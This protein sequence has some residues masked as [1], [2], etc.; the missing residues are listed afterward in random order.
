[1]YAVQTYMSLS[2]PVK[3]EVQK[4]SGRRERA[5]QRRQLLIE[6]TVEIIGRDGIDAVNHRRVADLAGVPLGSTTYYFA[7]RE[8]MLVQALEHF[9]RG[10]IKAL[11][12]R[13]DGLPGEHG[14]H[15]LIEEFVSFLAP[16]ADDTRARTVAQYTL[17]GE[18]A[19]RPALADVAR[20]WNESWWGLLTGVFEALGAEHPRLEARMFLGMLDGLLLAQLAAPEED[21]GARV[22]RPALRRW[23]ERLSR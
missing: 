15:E 17:F 2:K 10:E 21:F 9:G 1:M 11:H 18:A 8:D 4:P 12:E 22:L 14:A 20:Q 23:F 19:R 5:Q 6:T 16:Q 13:F 3:S 7:S